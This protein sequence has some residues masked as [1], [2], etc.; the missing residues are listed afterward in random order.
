MF[1]DFAEGTDFS[2]PFITEQATSFVSDPTILIIGI[3]LIVVT[4][5]LIFFMKKIIVNTILGLVVWG[6]VT[7]MFKFELPFIPSF[8]VSAVFG[9][10][11]VGVML[12]LKFL[13]VI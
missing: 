5:L 10:A 7:F 3:G 4:F 2:T 1:L 6:I 13:G 9:P 12:L 11:G 8:V